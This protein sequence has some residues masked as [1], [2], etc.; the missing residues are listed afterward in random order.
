MT[1]REPTARP[2]IFSDW[3][4]WRAAYNEYR[5]AY[6][7]GEIDRMRYRAMLVLLGFTP[8]GHDIEAEL[9]DALEE[10]GQ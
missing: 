5:S 8:G 1:A 6:L 9:S 7:R 4:D 10:R 2:E 3:E